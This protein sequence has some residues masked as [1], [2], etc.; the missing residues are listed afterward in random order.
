MAR[1]LAI[2]DQEAIRYTLK[3]MLENAGHDVTT[4]DSAGE[5][6]ERLRADA[7][8]LIITDI[9][10]E[11]MDGLE[12]L[13]TLKCTAGSAPTI[14]ISGG[15]QL[16]SAQDTLVSAEPFADA[17]LRKPFTARELREALDRVLG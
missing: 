4:A 17:V 14:A 2:D 12:L 6:L 3:L 5:A 1:V 7:Y 13:Q 16:L 8:D 10:M 15:G 9:L 11:D